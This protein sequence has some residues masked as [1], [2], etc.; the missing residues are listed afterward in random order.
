V[1]FILKSYFTVG[2]LLF[3]RKRNAIMQHELK[4]AASDTRGVTAECLTTAVSNS[5]GPI[6]AS[7]SAM[8]SKATIRFVSTYYYG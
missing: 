6:M 8:P 2:L 1:I 7:P 3:H 4:E 5:V